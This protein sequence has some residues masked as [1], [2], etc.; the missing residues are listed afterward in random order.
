MFFGIWENYINLTGF[1]S[2][3]GRKFCKWVSKASAVFHALNK[4]VSKFLLCFDQIVVEISH[5]TYI[6]RKMQNGFSSFEHIHLNSN[7]IDTNVFK[8]VL[9]ENITY[10]IFIGWLR[11]VYFFSHKSRFLF[12]QL[13]AYSKTALSQKK[14]NHIQWSAKEITVSFVYF[15]DLY[16]TMAQTNSSGTFFRCRAYIQECSEIAISTKVPFFRSRGITVR[17]LPLFCMCQPLTLQ[18]QN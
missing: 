9:F 8:Y 6:L 1:Q 17:A 7:S 2:L 12:I 4:K 11:K 18:Y 5:K 3:N 14:S 16:L 15:Y 13:F 10:R